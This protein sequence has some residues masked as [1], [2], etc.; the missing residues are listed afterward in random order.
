MSDPVPNIDLMEK[1]L[2]H[3]RI[4]PEDHDQAAFCGTAMCFA[5]WAAVLSKQYTPDE[6]T[7]LDSGIRWFNAGMELLGLT[8]Q[9]AATLFDPVN[10]LEHL[11]LMVKRIAAG[12]DTTQWNN[13]D[14]EVSWGVWN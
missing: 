2:E 10:E 8:R 6:W 7:S 1:V 13:G 5:G 9:Q 3:L 4:H 14:A 12:E 11:E